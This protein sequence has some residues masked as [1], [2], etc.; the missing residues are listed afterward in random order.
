MAASSCFYFDGR[1]PGIVFKS[2]S[3]FKREMFHRIFCL[4]LRLTRENLWISV[5]QHLELYGH[6]ILRTVPSGDHTSATTYVAILRRRSF[7]GFRH[8]VG[9]FQCLASVCQV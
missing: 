6:M 3:G 9:V 8:F 5:D 2:F 7:Q 1:V 4:S